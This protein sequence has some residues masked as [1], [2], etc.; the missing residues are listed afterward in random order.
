MEIVQGGLEV[1]CE[2]TVTMIGSVVN[3]LPL[4]PCESLLKE[5]YFEPKD[6]E[7]VRTFLS[8]AQHIYDKQSQDHD[9][10]N[11]NGKKRK[12]L[13]QETFGTC[14]ETQ[15]RK[16]ITIKK[17]LYLINKVLVKKYRS[18]NQLYD[19]TGYFTCI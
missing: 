12:N 17:L 9:N 16:Q 19:H 14:S 4:T 1:L 11:H 15:Q 18:C 2:V 13:I 5:L 6:E 10:L 8:L 7:I 3:H